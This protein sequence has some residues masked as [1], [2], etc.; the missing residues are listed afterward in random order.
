MRVV[1]NCKKGYNNGW[2]KIV[3]WVYNKKSIYKIKRVNKE[4]RKIGC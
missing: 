2:W 1:N 3:E 4:I